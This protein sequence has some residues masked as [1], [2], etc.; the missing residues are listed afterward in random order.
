SVRGARDEIRVP[1]ATPAPGNHHAVWRRGGCVAA[2][3]A[4]A[5]ERADASDRVSEWAIARLLGVIVLFVRASS[6]DLLGRVNR[7][8]GTRSL[9]RH[10]PDKHTVERSHVTK[11]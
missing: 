8:F 11:R 7:S 1:T 3:G 10:G 9:S 2:R 4:R 6:R 5:A